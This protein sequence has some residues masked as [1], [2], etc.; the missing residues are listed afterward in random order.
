VKTAV[1]A[2]IHGNLP[3]L[4]AVLADARGCGVER[5]LLAGDYI[6][7]LPWSN[8][9]T[10]TIR[11]LENMTAASGNKEGYLRDYWKNR[12]GWVYE[13]F[14]SIYQAVREMK[15]ENADYLMDLPQAAAEGNVY[16]TH[17]FPGFRD[18][19]KLACN[20]AQLYREAKQNPSYDREAF[21]RHL[22]DFLQQ[23]YVADALSG[24]DADI[25]VFGHVHIQW[26]GV[27][28][29]KLVLN[30]GSCGMPLDGDTRASYTILDGNQIDE[31]R[32][33]YDIE[34]AINE[35]K[36]SEVYRQGRV[37]AELCFAAMRSGFDTFFPHFERCERL[38]NERGE[39]GFPYSNEV[40]NLAFEAIGA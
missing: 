34:A 22:H 23:D 4:N 7:D 29:G 19:G 13:Q 25:V 21:V 20:S 15:P 26:H 32:V 33:A 14:G 28:G 8:E 31:R 18:G 5:Y 2:D 1:L 27:C 17:W 9:V 11:N 12:S 16:I 40:W 6:F 35:A 30:P 37:W 36:Q 3:A 24:I 39:T 38:A 10:E